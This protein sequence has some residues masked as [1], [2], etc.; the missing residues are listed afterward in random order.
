MEAGSITKQRAHLHAMWASVAEG[1][2]EH[3]D[4]ADARGAELTRA[5]L[6]ETSPRPGER[7]LEL[8]CGPGGLGL[9][10]AQHVGPR[11]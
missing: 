7:V 9:A 3:A 4:Y 10:A 11:R 2:A 6:D 8:A 5:I 1:W